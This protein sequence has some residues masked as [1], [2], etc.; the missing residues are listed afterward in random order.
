[1]ELPGAARAGMP[2]PPHGPGTDARRRMDGN[3][4][5][6]VNGDE[7]TSNIPAGDDDAPGRPVAALSDRELDDL[8]IQV[9]AGFPLDPTQS[10]RLVVWA[11]ELRRRTLAML[12]GMAA[13]FPAI[14]S[15]LGQQ[16][17]TVSGLLAANEELRE[18]VGRCLDAER[19]RSGYG[20]AA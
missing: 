8:E 6:H 3:G 13:A 18:T 5:Q 2:A 7:F 9:R 16:N 11:L 19:G 4:V 20:G 15:T 10:L 12:E 14:A 17:R 1:M